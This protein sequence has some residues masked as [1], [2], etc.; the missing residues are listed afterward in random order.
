MTPNEM[1]RNDDHAYLYKVTPEQDFVERVSKDMCTALHEKSVKMF[2]G[3]LND[4]RVFDPC[5]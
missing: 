4:G 5:C 3:Y 1:P 2:E